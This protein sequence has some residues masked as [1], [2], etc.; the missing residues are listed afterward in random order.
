MTPRPDSIPDILKGCELGLQPEYAD[1]PA[2]ARLKAD[3]RDLYIVSDLHLS[4]GTEHD[5]SYT[6][7]ENFFAD[8]SFQRF[9][10]SVS[11]ESEPGRAI[12]AIN[13]DF[14]DFLRIVKRPRAEADFSA[15]ATLL[16]QLG[17]ERSV[18]QLRRSITPK[19]IT[20]GLKTND[21]KSAWKLAAAVDGHQQFFDALADW[22]AHRNL[23]VILKGNHDL[24]WYWPAVRNT[25]RLKLA[26]RVA[27]GA[28][29]SRLRRA[30]EDVVIPGV[31]FVGHALLV[32]G[33]VYIEHGHMYDKFSHVLGAPVLSGK[34]NAELN[35]PFGSFF[36]RYL[37]NL[38][39]L[40]FPYFDNVRPQTSLLPLLFR[41]RFFLGLKVLFV[42]FP[43]MLQMIQKKYYEYMLNR[44]LVFSLAVGIP[45]A[46]VLWEVWNI[47]S[48]TLSQF[49]G[50]GP[51][52]PF[53][54]F[55]S[56]QATNAVVGLLGAGLSYGLARLTAWLQLEEPG[57]LDTFGRGKLNE[58]PGYRIVTFGHTHNPDQF[59]VASPV[60]PSGRWFYNTGTW[61]PVVEISSAEVRQDRTYTFL[62]LQNT[63]GG[64]QPGRLERWNDDAGRPEPMTLVRPKE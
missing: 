42:H 48:G 60:H 10:R 4:S 27:R 61:V 34:K 23:L 51:S 21:Y 15:W 37:I 56:D 14:V 3:G 49:A 25:L 38:V 40:D 7:T 32:D 54:K 57:S 41:E 31:R 18:D 5:G 13:G 2:I 63:G 62:H 44:A 33:E 1:Y 22:L 12:L 24:E 16:S 26:E 36:N 30:L 52:S 6:G 11:D 9:L 20:Y 28:A 46:L 35:I 47:L 64:L 53:L 55:L 8:G 43:F 50:S 58:H 19:E 39:E 59:V 17:I 29:G 45:G